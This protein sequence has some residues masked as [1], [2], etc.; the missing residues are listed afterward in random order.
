MTGTEKPELIKQMSCFTLLKKRA[1][2]QLG[3][4]NTHFGFAPTTAYEKYSSEDCII[5]TGHAVN[6]LYENIHD[7]CNYITEHT[8]CVWG[9]AVG[10]VGLRTALKAGRSRVRFPMVSL[11]FFIDIILPAAL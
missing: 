5:I 2:M 4:R 8:R 1:D 10:A 7:I 3:H 9:H 11:E 6:Y